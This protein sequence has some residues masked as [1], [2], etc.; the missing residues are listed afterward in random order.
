MVAGGKERQNQFLSNSPSPNES[1][2]LN[3]EFVIE[4]QDKFV[5][6]EIQIHYR[7][8]RLALNRDRF[9]VLAQGF[10]DALKELDEFEETTE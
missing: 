3:D 6:D 7:D 4:L 9:R 8:F 2:Y 5:T 10:S 1:K